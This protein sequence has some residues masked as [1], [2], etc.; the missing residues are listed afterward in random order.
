MTQQQ[1]DTM[2][3]GEAGLGAV[4]ERGDGGGEEVRVGRAASCW[5]FLLND[6]APGSEPAIM[7]YTIH[8]FRLLLCPA[9]PAISTA[10][11]FVLQCTVPPPS[12]SSRQP[13]P[14]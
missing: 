1:W 14:T 13:P 6:P 10:P 9:A 2:L 7:R 5:K 12:A 3:S 11:F 4:G 8:Q